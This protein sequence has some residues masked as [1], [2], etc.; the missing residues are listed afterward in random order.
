MERKE[1]N[2][3]FRINDEY[4]VDIVDMGDSGEGIGKVDGFTFFVGGGVVGDKL[5]VKL[6]TLK[7]SYAMAKMIEIVEPS[8]YRQKSDCPHF[9]ECGGCQLRHVA[10]EAQLEMKRKKVASTLERIGGFK[11]V[12]VQPVLG[13]DS[14]YH[15]RN[16][17]QFPAGQKEGRNIIG[18]YKRKTH[19]VQELNTCHLQSDLADQIV[20]RVKDWINTFPIEVYDE[21][22]HTG[23]L[24]HL[25]L[26]E[27]DATGEVMVVLV[28]NGKELP[29]ADEL[30]KSLT[31]EFSEVTTIVL[32]KNTKRGNRVLG[33]DNEILFGNGKITDK[34][35]DLKFE[36]SPL[37]FFQVNNEQTL[38]LYGTALDYAD[39][40]GQETVY[41]IYSGIGTISLFLAEKAKHVYGIEVI[42]AAVEDARE[43]ALRN[44]VTN[45]T[46]VVGKAEEEIHKMYDRGIV[47]DVVVV[48]PPRKG[49][50]ES[51][52]DTMLKMA[53]KR[54]VYVSCK[55]S[56]LARDLK[57]LCEHGPY[58]LEKVQPVDMFPWTSHVETLSLLIKK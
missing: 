57:Y 21:K 1:M 37:S 24:R 45:T 47:G 58:E 3:D 34:I 18:F 32:N 30:V 22:K 16:K 17:C 41:D 50:E 39:L 48:D 27:S 5:R 9:P 52:L 40:Q 2:M 15:Y 14:P 36:I 38:K 26:R 44:G 49:C 53:P 33:F 43:N 56:T 19:E 54:I 12:E 42:D 46:F 29:F 6:K 55:V 7:K 4:V 35:K 20:T 8:Q 11:G 51:V 23:L 10:Y 13:M 25:M 31:G 28:I